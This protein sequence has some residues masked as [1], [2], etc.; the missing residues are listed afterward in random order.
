MCEGDS[1]KRDQSLFRPRPVRGFHSEK[2]IFIPVDSPSG[3]IGKHLHSFAV[4]HK[5]TP[6]G[7]LFHIPNANVLYQCVGAPSAVLN[8]ER[9]IAS[10]AKDILM[11]GFCGALSS[12]PGIGDC[13]IAANTISDEGTSSHYLP[14]RTEFSP[15]PGLQH[16]M[17]SILNSRRIKFHHGTIVSTDAPFRETP[18]WKEKN[19]RRG[20][21]FVDME[22]SA[23]FALAE[24]HG[25]HAA[26]LLLVSDKLTGQKHLHGFGSS[27][28]SH[29]IKRCF[30]PF[31]TP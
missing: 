24:F 22:A 31:L 16:H 8:L 15:S 13:I 1:M 10:G 25:I 17:E 27:I 11:L 5:S 29:R 6:F 7:H 30:L 20:A 14:G 26:A 12:E 19:R 23:V 21:D 4:R 9:L 2:A 28:L 3:F 18:A